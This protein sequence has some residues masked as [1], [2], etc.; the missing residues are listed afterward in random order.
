[1]GLLISILVG[2]IAGFL[3]DLVF[4]RFSFSTIMQILLG[5][6]GG[7]VGGLIFGGSVGFLDRV[8]T[9]FAGAVIVLFV[10][11]LIKGQQKTV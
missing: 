6:V 7:F 1:M 8:L 9:A 3:A 2:A 4:K 11:G 10:A 5:I